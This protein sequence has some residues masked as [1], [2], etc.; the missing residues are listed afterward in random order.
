[1]ARKETKVTHEGNGQALEPLPE[2]SEQAIRELA[3]VFKLLSD[4][5][6]LR[7][8]FYL[9]SPRTASCT[10]PTCASGSARASRRSA[11]TWLCCGSPA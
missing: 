2:V 9:R 8:L 6:R 10:S 3:Q 1:M 7:I 11:T 5:T 4:E